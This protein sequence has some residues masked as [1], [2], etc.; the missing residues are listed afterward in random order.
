M[1][2]SCHFV[3][4]QCRQL[5]DEGVYNVTS[6][7][8]FRILEGNRGILAS[9]MG[10]VLRQRNRDRFHQLVD[11]VND[12]GQ[13]RGGLSDSVTPDEGVNNRLCKTAPGSQ[14]EPSSSLTQAYRQPVP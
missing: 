6:S 12:G 13:A 10:I 8:L 11:H 5:A 1:C 2:A 14:S 7:G 9:W 4:S 3:Y